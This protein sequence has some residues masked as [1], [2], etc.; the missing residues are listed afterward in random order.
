MIAPSVLAFAI[1]TFLFA[2]FVKGVIGMGLPT[3][4]MAFLTLALPPAEAASLLIVPSLATNIWQMVTGPHLAP[5]IRRLWLMVAGI[6]VGS[7]AGIGIMAHGETRDVIIFLGLALMIYALVGLSRLRF[8]V[9]ARHEWWLAPLV[10]GVTG[11]ISAATGVFAIPSVPYLGSLGLKKDELIQAL[12]LS[13]T[14]STVALGVVLTKN[15]SFHGV[16]ILLSCAAL[17]PALLGVVL[18]NWI[19]RRVREQMFRRVFY[20]GLLLLGGYFASGLIV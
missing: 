17:L 18:G 14:T 6:I 20:V 12:G 3:I 7:L 5:L 4:A 2:G 15:A 1:L 13:F 19:R 11:V 10:G 8:S 16:T 9:P